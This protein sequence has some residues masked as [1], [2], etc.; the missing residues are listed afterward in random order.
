MDDFDAKSGQVIK[1]AAGQFKER[2][3]SLTLFSYSKSIKQ[4]VFLLDFFIQGPIPVWSA[5][6]TLNMVL[7][8][9]VPSLAEAICPK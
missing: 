7:L 6:M 5:T 9:M 4:N 2:Q 8:L 3:C 1:A